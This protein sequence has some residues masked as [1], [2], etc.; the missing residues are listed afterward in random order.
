MEFWIEQAN[1]IDKMEDNEA[2]IDFYHRGEE[3][4]RDMEMFISNSYHE[5]YTE[6]AHHCC[7]EETIFE[8]YLEEEIIVIMDGM[9]FR[10]S[11]LLYKKLKELNLNLEHNY[12]FSAIPSDTI[13][14]REKINLSMSQFTEIR[15][16]D[17][18]NIESGKTK[19]W[20]RFPDVL[21][22]KLKSGRTMISPINELYN[23]VESII[24]LLLEEFEEKKIIISS[25]HGYIRVEPVYTFSL[26][27]NVIKHMKKL[28]RGRRYIESTPSL[29]INASCEP[30]IEESNNHIMVCSRNIW[31]IGGSYS[32]II[33]GGLSL[34]ECYIPVL[35]INQ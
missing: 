1:N 14:F 10:E 22:D 3:R 26:P 6:L 12:S 4:C 2:I 32:S 28:F 34:M 27:K 7:T 17:E 11:A 5:F 23:S 20:S 29:S 21:F 18:I 25:D 33:H 9:S 16:K 15:K 13:F 31:P 19:L 8:K 24:L 30:Y 35:V